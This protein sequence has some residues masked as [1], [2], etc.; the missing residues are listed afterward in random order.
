MATLSGYRQNP[1]LIP[2]TVES[3]FFLD[4]YFYIFGEQ[5]RAD[6]G[7]KIAPKAKNLI[8]GIFRAK[9]FS[10]AFFSARDNFL[11][12]TTKIVKIQT[13]LPVLE[14]VLDRT[15]ET[16]WVSFEGGRVSLGDIH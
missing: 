8:I 9:H 5:I 2:K 16:K 12:F 7:K 3:K 1:P 4:L 10:H 14:G 11:F 6:F 13:S 15:A